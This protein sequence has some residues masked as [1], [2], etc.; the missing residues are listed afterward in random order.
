[1]TG[2]QNVDVGGALY[3]V[4]FLDGTYTARF[5]GC[6]AV[7]ISQ[8]RQTLLRQSQLKPFW[9]R[10]SWTSRPAIRQSGALTRGCFGSI[11]GVC[12]VEVPIVFRRE[13]DHVSCYNTLDP[14]FDGT[15]VDA[16][17]PSL[18]LTSAPAATWARFTPS[19]QTAILEPTSL[20]LLGTGVA[21]VLAKVRRRRQAK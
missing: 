7:T 17:P 5:S 20:L 4:E 8:L 3:D 16:F 11:A 12:F 19:Q 10:C 1:M 14:S 6:D 21:G 13:R 9:T 18:D 2:A 15:V